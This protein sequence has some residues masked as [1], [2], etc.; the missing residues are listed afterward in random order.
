[1]ANAN[2]KGLIKITLTGCAFLLCMTST[3][4]A[5]WG[6]DLSRRTQQ[7]SQKELGVEQENNENERSPASIRSVRPQ[8]PDEVV[9]PAAG[10]SAAKSDGFFDRI[11]DPGESTQDI[12]ILNTDHGFVP[13]NIR[14]KRDGRYRMHIVNVNEKDKNV[15]FIL[16]GFSEHHATYFGKVKTFKLEPKKDGVFSFISPETAA[17]GRLVIYSGAENSIRPTAEENNTEPAGHVVSLD[18]GRANRRN[19]P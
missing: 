15:S 9:D 19:E 2:K 12:V 10:R 7:L 11:F 8:K 6:I 5:D 13:A 1:M 17:E 14:L 3:A 16:D 18:S 4:F